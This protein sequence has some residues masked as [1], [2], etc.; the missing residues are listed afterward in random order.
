MNPVQKYFY[1]L[2]NIR[3]AERL[4][5]AKPSPEIN[6]NN[7]K[8]FY[9]KQNYYKSHICKNYIDGQKIKKSK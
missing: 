9:K 3:L 7:H 1:K 8:K 6:K 2:D 4:L 5:I